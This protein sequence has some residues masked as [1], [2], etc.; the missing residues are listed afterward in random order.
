VAFAGLERGVLMVPVPGHFLPVRAF[1]GK[2][3]QVG[4]EA[5]RRGLV[6]AVPE[7]LLHV[8]QPGDRLGQRPGQIRVVGVRDAAGVIAHERAVG[9]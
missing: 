9:A 8:Q 7:N 3:E 4:E 6:G 1:P 2:V 5:H